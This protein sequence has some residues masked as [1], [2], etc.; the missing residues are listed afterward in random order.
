MTITTDL[1]TEAWLP[2]GNLP[3]VLL[4][5][6]HASFSA[7]IRVVNNNENVVSNGETFLKYPFRITLPNKL[8]NAPPTAR[9]EIDNVSREIG[10]AIR[11][12][13]S[14]PTVEISVIRREDPDTLEIALQPMSLQNASVDALVVS[15]D[16]VYENLSQEPFPAITYSPAEYP[17]L[18]G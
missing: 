17:G 10:Q 13:D 9:L 5:I 15:G 4:K 1:K 12:A 3:F 16:L 6:D 2:E 18:V 8:D 7:P 14:P 11:L